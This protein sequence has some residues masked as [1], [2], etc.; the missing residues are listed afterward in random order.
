MTIRPETFQYIR[1]ALHRRTA[2]HLMDNKE[3]LVET[4]LSLL[5]RQ[6]GMRSV[7]DLV[8]HLRTLGSSVL[9]PD[10]VDAMTTNETSFFRDST[11]FHV[12]R[13]EVFPEL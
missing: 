3:Y 2:I 9:W 8:D 1:E 6:N 11:P 10:V 5:A 4:R 7:D 12:L 13:D